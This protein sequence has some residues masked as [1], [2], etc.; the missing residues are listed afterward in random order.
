MNDKRFI[1]DTFNAYAKLLKP[2][3]HP[4]TP[5]KLNNIPHAPTIGRHIVCVC[6]RVKGIIPIYMPRIY[7]RYAEPAFYGPACKLYTLS[8]LINRRVKQSIN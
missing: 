3:T 2:L 4:F 8:P 7:R 1:I 6:V 5:E